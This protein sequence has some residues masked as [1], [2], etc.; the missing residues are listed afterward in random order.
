MEKWLTPGPMEEMK[1][2]L[3][4]SV[5]ARMLESTQKKKN[6]ED[7]SKGPRNQLEK[8]HTGQIWDNLSNTVANNNNGI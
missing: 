6:D 4:I 1:M 5:H 7:M 3:G 8:I 2:S